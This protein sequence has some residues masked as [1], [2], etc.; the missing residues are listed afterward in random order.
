MLHK[1]VFDSVRWL[2]W[3]VLKCYS[4]FLLVPY[5]EQEQMPQMWTLVSW[6]SRRSARWMWSLCELLMWLTRAVFVLTPPRLPLWCWE[7]PA[8]RHLKILKTA[9]CRMSCLARGHCCG[10][11]HGAALSSNLSWRLVRLGAGLVVGRVLCRVLLQVD[12]GLGYSFALCALC[13]AVVAGGPLW[14]VVFGG[15]V[16]CLPPWRRPGDSHWSSLL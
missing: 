5:T 15:R 7:Q 12:F 2:G 11:A 8:S 10:A 6:H 1:S 4:N 3:L 9:L 16:D 14:C 13:L